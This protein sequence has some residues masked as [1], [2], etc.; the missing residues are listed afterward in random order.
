MNPKRVLLMI[1]ALIIAIFIP[2]ILFTAYN[3]YVIKL[4]FYNYTFI[5][6]FNVFIA[7]VFGLWITLYLSSKTSN[8]VKKSEIVFECIDSILDIYKRIVDCFEQCNDSSLNDENRRRCIKLFRDASKEISNLDKYINAS[9]NPSI[10]IATKVKGISYVTFE[11][12]K[13][14]T[15]KPF[16]N[17]YIITIDDINQS[18]DKYYEIKGYLQQLKMLLF[19]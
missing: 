9:M 17:R 18:S 14:I 16:S 6:L 4:N 8:Y 11:L 7:L 12:K 1:F 3:W 2:L 13:I 15:D 5:D 10:N 19:E